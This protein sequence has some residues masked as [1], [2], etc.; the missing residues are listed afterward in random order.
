MEM[1]IVVLDRRGQCTTEV[2][3]TVIGGWEGFVIL[4]QNVFKS[5]N[6]KVKYRLQHNSL[7][8]LGNERFSR[9]QFIQEEDVCIKR[10]NGEQERT[11]ECPGNRGLWVWMS[12]QS[13]PL[14]WRQVYQE[15]WNSKILEWN[16][17][18]EDKD[19]DIM[20]DLVWRSG[21]K[22]KIVERLEIMR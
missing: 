10:H 14:L 18:G 9:N 17:M 2:Y 19:E 6:I 21:D 12:T 3:D 5:W 13:E 20:K 7:R 1:F 11:K 4:I 8:V 16:L 15:N 22:R